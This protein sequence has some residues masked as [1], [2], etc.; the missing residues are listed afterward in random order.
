MAS[1]M[2]VF[3]SAIVLVLSATSTCGTDV[4]FFTFDGVHFGRMLEESVGTGFGTGTDDIDEIFD[5]GAGTVEPTIEPTVEPTIE[6]TFDPPVEPTTEPTVE[7]TIEPTVEP[8][9]EPTVEPTTK[10]TV[11]PTIEPTV[12]P[13]AV[14]DVGTGTGTGVDYGTGTGTGDIDE[15]SETGSG[16]GTGALSEYYLLPVGKVA[17]PAGSEVM[18]YSECYD[19]IESLGVCVTGGIGGNSTRIPSSCVYVPESCDADINFLYNTD[20][21]ETRDDS[22]LVCRGVA[23]PTA[24]PTASPTIEATAPTTFEPTVEPTVESTVEATVEPTARPTSALTAEPTV[25]PTVEPS[26]PAPEPTAVPTF[27]AAPVPATPSPTVP[28]TPSPTVPATPSPTV[29]ASSAKKVNMELTIKMEQ[30]AVQIRNNEPLMKGLQESGVT[31]LK[32]LVP[33]AMIEFDMVEVTISQ[34]PMSSVRRL[35]EESNLIIVGYAVDLPSSQADTLVQVY[36]TKDKYEMASLVVDAFDAA[37]LPTDSMAL[38]AVGSCLDAC[39]E[40]KIVIQMQTSA[41]T[42]APT[43]SPSL[44]SL[45][46]LSETGANE[47]ASVVEITIETNTT[48]EANETDNDDFEEVESSNAPRL[49]RFLAVAVSILSVASTALA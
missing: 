12:E 28:A 29:P 33:G 11:E 9:I 22:S 31:F 6:P 16:S 45:D 3:G 1:N 18:S 48:N 43:S 49:A 32:Q 42:G 13:T 7:P 4:D 26:A 27:S 19:A 47:V 23:P 10:P 8:T 41:P 37:N 5:T 36:S 14:T 24:S 35:K 17:C 21:T 44:N 34:G 15:I 25:E 20:D 40:G 30:T 39:E 2:Q 38:V 46:P